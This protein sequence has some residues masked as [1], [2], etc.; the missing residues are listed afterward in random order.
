MLGMMKETSKLPIHVK[1][2]MGV[3]VITF[4]VHAFFLDS[5]IHLVSF[6]TFFVTLAIFAPI[7]FSMTKNVSSIAASHFVAWPIVLASGIVQLYA[8]G[9]PESVTSA[10]LVLFA[11]YAV[12]F[13]SLVLDYRIILNELRISARS[14]NQS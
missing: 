11:G 13:I 2:W 12:F 4:G 3:M 14:Q 8:Q 5:Q 1:A 10:D 6:A 7:S 9:M